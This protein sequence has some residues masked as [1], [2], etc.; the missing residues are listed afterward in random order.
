MRKL[1]FYTILISVAYC[2]APRLFDDRRE[3]AAASTIRTDDAGG[4]REDGWHQA[5]P[6]PSP[7]RTAKSRRSRR[8]VEADQGPVNRSGSTHPREADADLEP[9]AAYFK[10]T[11]SQPPE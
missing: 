1:F 10:K 8:K 6:R 4:P 2:L 9:E 7:R 11:G 5:G 3:P